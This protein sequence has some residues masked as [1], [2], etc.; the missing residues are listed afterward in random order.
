M[1][2]ERFVDA[3]S[4]AAAL[5]ARQQRK[6]SG[7]PYLAHLMAVSATVMEFGG[8][9]N[10]AIA[11]LLHDAA[12]DQGGLAT[13]AQIRE[14]FGQRVANIVEGCTDTTEN[15]KPPWRPRKEAYIARLQNATASVR[16]VT[17]ADKLHNARAILREYRGLGESLWSHFRGGRD[18]TLWYY[19]T[20]V[21]TLQKAEITPLVEELD[22]AV[23]ELQQ[24]AGKG[25]N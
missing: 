21:E 20:V 4:Y 17:A 12:E 18:G 9:E 11:G 14:K 2:T 15:P 24:R 3:F 8:D 23:A 25:E 7:G 13:L 1:Q 5:H 22:R 16:L 6:L 10:E 19:R